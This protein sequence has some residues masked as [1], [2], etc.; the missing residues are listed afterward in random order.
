M[1]QQESRA[2]RDRIPLSSRSFEFSELLPCVI[3]RQ[4][5]EALIDLDKWHIFEAENPQI[6]RQMYVF[7]LRK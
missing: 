6:F 1:P 2:R 4:C 7:T 3:A 5:G